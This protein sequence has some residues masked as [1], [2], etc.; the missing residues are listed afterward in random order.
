MQQPRCLFAHGAGGFAQDRELAERMATALGLALDYPRLPDPSLPI[1]D[2]ARVITDAWE[3]GSATVLIG[4]S[5]GG[6]A[7]LHALPELEPGPHAVVLLAAPNWGP[8]GWDVQ[9]YLPPPVPAGLTVQAHHCVDDEVVP[10]EHLDLNR[11][12]LRGSRGWR[13]ERGGHQ[14]VGLSDQVAAIARVTTDR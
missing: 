9:D 4:H 10:V 3:A 7:T 13:H 6:T 5:F 12:M 14:F 8:S 1:Q 11:A 2:A